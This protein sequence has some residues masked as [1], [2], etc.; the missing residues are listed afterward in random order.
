MGERK[1]CGG[2]ASAGHWTRNSRRDVCDTPLPVWCPRMA[3]AHA[4]FMHITVEFPDDGRADKLRAGHAA[5]A[6]RWITSA[7]GAFSLNL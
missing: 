4:A 1:S 5:L 2:M 3:E 6:T 7:H